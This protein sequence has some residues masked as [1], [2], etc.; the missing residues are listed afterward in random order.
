[1]RSLAQIFYIEIASFFN[2]IWWIINKKTRSV[3]DVGCG[4]G[5]NGI[6]LAKR[7]SKL[8]LIG[9]DIFQKYL[10]IAKERNCYKKLVKKDI[11][12][13]SY[14]KKSFDCVLCLQVIEHLN[15]KEA[16]KL[17]GKIERIAKHQVI[18]T[19]PIGV[20]RQSEIGG[21]RHQVHKSSFTTGDFESLGY[22]IKLMGN[23]WLSS[24]EGIQKS[25]I[26]SIVRS[27]F[28]F[29]DVLLTPIYYIFPFLAN[30]YFIAY[31]DLS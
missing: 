1:M 24:Q 6:L 15:K 29:L 14:P 12:K 4:D 2:P 5:K 30:H 16:N 19:S 20:L 17:I 8:N 3:F 13:I 31:K 21:N 26:S 9:V 10:N 28:L 7:M 18:I 23:R 22:R 25:N 11:R 27:A